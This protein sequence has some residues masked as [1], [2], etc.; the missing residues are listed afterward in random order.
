MDGRVQKFT[1]DGK[2]LFA[3]GDLKDHPGSFG[4]RIQTNAQHART[5]RH[6]LRS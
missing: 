1:P 3:F 6:L 2:F 4:A 5:H